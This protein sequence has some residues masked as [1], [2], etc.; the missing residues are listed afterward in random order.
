MSQDVKIIV[1]EPVLT[2]QSQAP[3]KEGFIKIWKSD[4]IT[5][6]SELIVDK[7]NT[8]LYTGSDLLAKALGGEPNTAISHM[9]LGYSNNS[10]QPAPGYT[11]AKDATTFSTTTPLGYLRVPLTF[12]ASFL[13]ETNYDNNIVVFTILINN[14][15]GYQVTTGSPAALTTT[16]SAF[17]EAAL[18]SALDPAGTV[19]SHPKDKIFARVAFERVTYDSSFNLTLSWGVKFVS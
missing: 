6:K 16:T 15:S 12:P 11:I 13:K 4:P 18:V 3:A 14:A 7:K 19:N 1:P 5:G 2:T 10:G 17:F 8:I 9:Y